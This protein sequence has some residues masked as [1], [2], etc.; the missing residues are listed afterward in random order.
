MKVVIYYE[1][2]SERCMLNH[3]I[4]SS[5]Q[6]I[7]VTEDYI[8]FL[9]AP[10]TQNYMLLYDCEGYQNVFP[11]V[12]ETFYCYP[13]NER[14]IIIRDLESTNCF[15]LLKDELNVYCPNLPVIRAKSVFAK[16]KLEHLYL[17][18]LNIFRRV[19]HSIYESKFRRQIS[20]SN[21]LE[22]LISK[23]DPTKPDISGLF[24]MYNMAFNKPTVANEFFARF[25]FYNSNHPYFIRLVNSLS[26][27]I[28]PQRC[29][30]FLNFT[31]VRSH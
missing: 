6:P 28:Q 16:Y 31:S 14:V 9:T 2:P 1:G 10:D 12:R 13:S 18:D 3:L 29:K 27:L 5:Y 24:R 20:D 8:D 4:H 11:R 17:A 19:F 25:D 21:K 23:L 22:R 15:S 26:E 7:N 30:N